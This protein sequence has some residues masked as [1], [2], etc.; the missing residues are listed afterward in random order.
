MAK[1]LKQIELRIIGET[2]AAGVWQLRTS[3]TLAVAIEEY[4][5]FEPKKKGISINLTAAEETVIKNFVKD[6]VLPQAE[7]AK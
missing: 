2:D 7:A 1:L 4:P 5:D 3:A 6:V